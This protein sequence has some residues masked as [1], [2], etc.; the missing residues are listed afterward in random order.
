MSTLTVPAEVM[1]TS[2]RNARDD[3]S[4]VTATEREPEGT[5]DFSV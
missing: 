1:C 5:L 2:T 3:V 4:D